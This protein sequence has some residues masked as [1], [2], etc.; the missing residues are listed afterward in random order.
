MLIAYIVFFAYEILW[1]NFDG[2]PL[3]GGIDCS[4]DMKE[5]R[6]CRPYLNVQGVAKNVP[7]ENCYFSEAA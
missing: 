6:H 1:R 5:Y 3:T 4:W 2:V 7:D